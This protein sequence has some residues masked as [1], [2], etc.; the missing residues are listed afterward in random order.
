MKIPQHLLRLSLNLQADL[1]KHHSLH[2]FH[3]CQLS[4]VLTTLSLTTQLDSRF[5]SKFHFTNV[6][7]FTSFIP[8]VFYL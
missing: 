6:P 7:D 3:S 8:L 5:I 2:F 1:P 4:E